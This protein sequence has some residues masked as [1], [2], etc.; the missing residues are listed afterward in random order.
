MGGR[1][2]EVVQ[3]L[4]NPPNS[5]GIKVVAP[6]TQYMQELSGL[7]IARLYVDHDAW[8]KEPMTTYNFAEVL[9]GRIR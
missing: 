5:V 9:K 6:T 8:S 3:G 7:K 4:N 2:E 1:R